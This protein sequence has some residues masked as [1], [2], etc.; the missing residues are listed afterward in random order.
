[1]DFWLQI[2][3]QHVLVKCFERDLF[4]GFF[5]YV[6]LLFLFFPDNIK[7]IWSDFQILLHSVDYV[8]C[9]LVLFGFDFNSVW[10]WI[11]SLYLRCLLHA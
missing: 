8:G 4:E 6:F 3:L 2:F 9:I 5:V 11:K 1:M 7:I 10:C